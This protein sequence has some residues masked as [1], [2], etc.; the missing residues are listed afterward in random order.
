MAETMKR[1]LGASLDA[2]Y[3]RGKRARFAPE[4]LQ[5]RVS[6]VGP[7]HFRVAQCGGF[8]L[9]LPS[10]RVR[11]WHG[12]K[13]VAPVLIDVSDLRA[14]CVCG[15]FSEY[16]SPQFCPGTIDSTSEL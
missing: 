7:V 1:D 13:A 8:P 12:G 11:V 6:F 3:G 4:K 15:I 5:S 2:S 10:E 9:G 14:R 16:C